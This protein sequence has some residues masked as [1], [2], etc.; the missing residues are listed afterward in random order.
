MFLVSSP[1]NIAEV[2]GSSNIACN[3]FVLFLSVIHTHMTDTMTGSCLEM[4]N[5][6]NE[7]TQDRVEESESVNRGCKKQS[8]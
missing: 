4:M 8:G 2:R 6:D 5:L 7:W 1:V 3:I